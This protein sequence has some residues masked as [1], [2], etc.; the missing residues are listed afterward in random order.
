L[1]EDETLPLRIAVLLSGSGRTLRNLIEVIAAGSL[2][3][4]IVV[5]ISSV[6]GAGGIDVARDAGIPAATIQRREFDSDQAFSDAVYAAISPFQPDLILLAGFLRRLVVAPAWSGRMLNIHPALLPE[7]GVAGRGFYGDRVHAAVLASGATASG[8]TVHVVDNDYDTGPVVLRQTV[9]VQP[10]D[11]T[12]TLA[13]RV[14]AAECELYPA[15]IRAHVTAHPELFG[16]R[17]I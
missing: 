14:F 15:A 10:G 7:S 2:R 1:E 9:P 5:V 17:C 4:E 13:A 6:E 12:A 3:A 11:T 16:E 8:A